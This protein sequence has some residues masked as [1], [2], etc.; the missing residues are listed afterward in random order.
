M[1][2][3]YL[4]EWGWSD[5]AGMAYVFGMCGSVSAGVN[6]V[7]YHHYVVMAIDNNIFSACLLCS[8]FQK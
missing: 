1:S 4:S 2:R 6:R 8:N 3:F 7:G 5:C